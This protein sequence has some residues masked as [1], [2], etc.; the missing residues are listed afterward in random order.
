LQFDESSIKRWLVSL[1][2]EGYLEIET[3]KKGFTSARRIYLGDDFKKVL[4]R[5]ENEPP[6]AQNRAPR[7]LKIEPHKE[8]KLK[9]NKY[10]KEQQQSYIAKPLPLSVL[11][12]PVAVSSDQ[13][14]KTNNKCNDPAIIEKLKS[15]GFTAS[16]IKDV[17]IR[18]TTEEIQKGIAYATHPDTP[19]RTN[20]IATIKWACKEKIEPPK[21]KENLLKENGNLVRKFDNRV[22]SNGTIRIE[23]LSKHVEFIF[24]GCQKEPIFLSFEDK[25]FKNR[26]LEQLKKNNFKE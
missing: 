20:I 16:D 3:S 13:Q 18:Y 15:L 7:E 4:R 11:S 1:S 9:E 24:L 26:F 23:V 5:L 21:N 10:L 8:N 12:S 19:I 2:D 6:E 25:D 17:L 22:N 14:Y